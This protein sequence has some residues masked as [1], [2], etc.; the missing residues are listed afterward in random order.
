MIFKGLLVLVGASFRWAR[1]TWSQRGRLPA[2]KDSAHCR[3]Q[4]LRPSSLRV[5]SFGSTSPAP[6]KSPSPEASSAKTSCSRSTSNRRTWSS[7]RRRRS[8]DEA[9]QVRFR[10]DHGAASLP[11]RFVQV[12]AK[13]VSGATATRA[14]D[15]REPTAGCPRANRKRQQDARCRVRT[16]DATTMERARSCFQSTAHPR[17]TSARAVYYNGRPRS[18]HC[19]RRF[20]ERARDADPR[21]ES[22]RVALA[23][24]LYFTGNTIVIDHGARLFSVFAHL[25]AV[26]G[27]GR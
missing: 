7:A 15:V 24:P 14:R 2:R 23:A 11:T 8:R 21:I 16:N 12:H 13:R 9:G 4:C 27:E 10:I 20:H 22:W 18:P 1:L 5:T 6:P 25:S 3:C 26:S 19:R 17:A